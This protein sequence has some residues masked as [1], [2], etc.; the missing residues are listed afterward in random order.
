MKQS[1][2][3]PGLEQVAHTIAYDGTIMGDTMSGKPLPTDRWTAATM[4]TL[5]MNGGNSELFSTLPPALANLLPNARHRPIPDQ[6]TTSPATFAPILID[7][8]NP[9]QLPTND[10]GRG[11][12]ET[13]PPRH[14]STHSPS[15]MG[16]PIANAQTHELTDAT[17]APTHR[18]TDA[19][20]P[21]PPLWHTT[22]AP[23]A[24]FHPGAP[25]VNTPPP[26]SSPSPKCSRR[27]AAPA[28]PT[29]PPASKS[30]LRTIR[31]YIVM[32]QEMGIPIESR[33]GRYGG[34]R[35]RPG[36]RLPPLMLAD[37]EALAVTLGLLFARR[38]GLTGAAPATEGALAK[39]ERVLP[40][41]LRAQVNASRRRHHP[42][43]APPAPARRHP[44]P[45]PLRHPPH[46][47]RRRRRRVD[48][49]P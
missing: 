48:A 44:G 16:N 22:G 11:G 40:A 12:S 34:Y 43:L 39:I 17:D 31:R 45:R 10:S 5:V 49:P 37:D 18:R 29:S 27:A 47:R 19:L 28:A 35:L 21:V 4:P 2:M 36:F 33:P 24:S 20:A 26:A 6:T 23:P 38:F 30:I 15:D 9:H 13:R 8:F 41:P 7:F 3:W 25:H 32:L 14:Q 42:R 1:P 46:P